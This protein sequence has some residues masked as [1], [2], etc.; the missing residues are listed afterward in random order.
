MHKRVTLE[1]PGMPIGEIAAL[2]PDQLALLAGEAAEA[3][4]RAHR[5]KDWVD[6]AP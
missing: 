1:D 6:G 4:E 2:P 3:L 5:V